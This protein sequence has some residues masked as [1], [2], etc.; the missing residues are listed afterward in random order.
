MFRT[1]FRVGPSL[2][3]GPALMVV[4]ALLA[5]GLCA[6]TAFA[7]GASV[8]QASK[9]QKAEALKDYREGLKAFD[10]KNYELALKLLRQSHETVASPNSQLVI[11]HTLVQ[12]GRETE[13]YRELQAAV[14]LAHEL[15]KVDDK[16]AKTA[17]GAQKELDDLGK[18]LAFVVVQP[19]AQV[20]L[21]DQDVP[22]VEW[23]RPQPLRPGKVKVVVRH[24]GGE[25]VT[26]ELDLAAGEHKDLSTA[27]PPPPQPVVA[28]KP[29]PVVTVVRE[30]NPDA[31]RK[32]TLAYATG[33]VGLAGVGMF[34]A[35]TILSSSINSREGCTGGVCPE[36]TLDNATVSGSYQT[37]T[38][39]G[40]GV[41]VI[42]LGTSAYLFA[43]SSGD[44]SNEEPV[45]E[46][47]I[48]PGRVMVQG[49][50]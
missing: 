15:A 23:G 44:S 42:G 14:R 1:T 9:K 25:E 38:F 46:L 22:H 27:P 33:A 13:A 21:G 40:L 50:F 20:T 41:G 26:T 28:Q 32:R 29:K 19:N 10:A 18:K 8:T 35:F 37:L 31:V 3:D 6:K 4:A 16:Y 43:T 17:E 2:R 39:V 45:A 24:Q 5:G 49:A 30:K 36:G 7:E 11:A 12:L 47:A 48:G 34:A